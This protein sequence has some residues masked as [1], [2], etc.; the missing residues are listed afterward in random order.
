MGNSR[1]SEE[2]L[3]EHINT[4]GEEFGQVYN[5][6]YR[7]IMFI[8]CKW[9]EFETLFGEGMKP[10]ETMNKLA[11]L[12]FYIIQNNLFDDVILSICRITDP[13][14]STGK[15][16]LTF[17][18]IPEYVDEAIR[19]TITE[20]V[21]NIIVDSSFC[22][23]RRNRLISHLDR[24]LALNRTAKPLEPA[25]RNKVNNLLK[26]FQELIDTIEGHYYNS[27]VYWEFARPEG[28]SLLNWAEQGLQLENLKWKLN[29]TGKLELKDF[30][31]DEN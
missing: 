7:E 24:D 9:S 2:I 26:R 3:E 27:Q 29:H 25:N 13:I 31:N 1:T 15:Y 19:P 10:I 17:R 6:L 14:K 8:H 5:R 16:N 21:E 23:D 30:E 20:Q 4:L 11:P 22:R 12:F 18:L 28:H